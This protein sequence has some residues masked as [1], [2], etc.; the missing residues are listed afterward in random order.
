MIRDKKNA[1]A[2]SST[3][4]AERVA[5]PPEKRVTLR[6]KNSTF[7]FGTQDPLTA[8]AFLGMVK[9]PKNSRGVAIAFL[10]FPG[11]KK[12]LPAV[13]AISALW[14]DQ[15]GMAATSGIREDPEVSRGPGSVVTMPFSFNPFNSLGGHHGC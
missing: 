3:S 15:I 10:S 9:V 12:V 14:R 6:K 8:A 1:P 13:F 11:I 5:R 2:L 7:A 4:G